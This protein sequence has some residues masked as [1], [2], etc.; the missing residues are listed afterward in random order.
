[1]QSLAAFFG[2]ERPIRLFCQD[3]SRIGLH[4]PCYRRLTAF[5]T[6]PR[7]LVEPLYEYYWLY[8][9]VEPTTGEAFYL[10]MPWLNSE[11]FSI[12]LRELA[13]HY[14]DSLCVVLLDNAPAHLA[15]AVAVPENVVLLFLPPYS[16]ELNPVERLWQDI[17]RRIDVF[18]KAVRSSLEGLKRQVAEIVRSYTSTEIASLTG[19]DYLLDAVNAL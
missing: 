16:P 8:G 11:C 1:M 4:L 3:E 2:S 5:G 9:A 14:S 7:Q 13:R 15:R 10:E 19:Y 12:Y 18:D 6:K 17:K